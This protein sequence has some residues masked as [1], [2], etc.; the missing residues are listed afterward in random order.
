ARSQEYARVLDRYIARLVSRRQLRDALAVYRREI[1]R[2]P[3]DPGLYAAAAQFLEQ[4]SLTSEVEQVYRLAIQQFPDRSWHHRLARWYVRR[5]QSAA[6]ETLTRDVTRTFEGT[7]LARYFQ[8]VV[9]RGPA[10][11]A[12]LFLQLN[13]YA[14]ER[15]P[16]HLMFVRNLL[17]AYATTA[18][19]NPAAREA[20]L[21]QHWFE[22]DA[23]AAEFFTLLSR[24]NRLD[25]EIAGMRGVS[26]AANEANWGRLAKEHPLAARFLAEAE[27][28]R[29]RFEPAT[30]VISALA[31]EFPADVELNQR[32]GSLHRSLSYADARE[33]DAAART[34]DLLYRY[35]PRSRATLT[36]LGE[37]HADR[38]RYDRARAY[39]DRLPD[40]E[41]GNPAGYLEAATVF[42]DYY[43][44]DDALRI[45]AQCRT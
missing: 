21:R 38:E 12:Q 15:F 23:L 22:D 33:T 41:P 5:T 20:L 37:I 2:N 35:D 32:A 27:I 9:A 24:T 39:W 3:N 10:V 40:I 43:Q 8:A 36:T 17:S 42:W 31:I 44:F 25:A 7:D 26:T 16:H 11:N 19:L 4:N 13:L 14:H 30:P 34:V 45:I 29:S 1:D 28:W 6:F 18:T